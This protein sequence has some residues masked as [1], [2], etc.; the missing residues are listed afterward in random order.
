MT[1]PAAHS[2]DRRGSA[3]ILPVAVAITTFLVLLAAGT[4]KVSFYLDALERKGLF[5]TLPIVACLGMFVL[6]AYPRLPVYA[7]A[8]LLP[9]NFVGGV[10]G[11]HFVVL[12]AKIGVNI[13]VFA[14]IVAT[15]CAPR[16]H[17]QWLTRTA[18]G[19]ALL[20]WLLFV[21][22]GIVIGSVSVP[23]RGD[24][25]RESIWMSFFA[26]ALPVGTLLRNRREIIRTLQ[27]ACAG[28]FVLQA[29]A[30]WLVVTGQRYE[31]ADAWSAGQTF[32]RAPFSPESLLVLYLAAAALLY[33][34]PQ[35]KLSR[36]TEWLL[37]AGIAV[38]GGGLL[39]SMGR[40]LWI[41]GAIG[42]FVVLV[43]VPWNRRT[44]GAA[45]AVAAGAA[46]AVAVV[47]VVDSLSAGSSGRWV[48]AA[49]T[50]FLDLGARDSTSTVTRQLEWIHAIDVWEKSPIV[51]LGFGYPFPIITIG[52]VADSV[53]PDAFYMH[54]SYLNVLAKCGALGLL[55]LL[56]FLRRTIES[57]LW[58]VRRSATLPERIF[59]T[60]LIA[61]VVQILIYAMFTPALTASDT[62]AYFG[63]LVGLAA[64]ARRIMQPENAT[65]SP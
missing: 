56:L 65:C 63:M 14:A 39:A 16:I 44:V 21:G 49:T 29:Y 32:F 62:V 6:L 58:S 17:R 37:V 4:F 64:A 2:V 1:V 27:A 31:R 52:K 7:L 50:F 22:I 5:Y 33:Y 55:A 38:L 26:F 40:S 10:W 46:L 25:L 30:F 24:W 9:F 45:V 53:I 43:L 48:A 60:A 19:H 15:F 35:R 41:S 13:T 51:G 12:V 59:A 18:L 34:A 57:L 47:I 42:L 3:W 36:S 28:V 23:V 8:F 11:D 54:N 61:A 20:L